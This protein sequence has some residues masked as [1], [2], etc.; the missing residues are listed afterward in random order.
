[1]CIL[2]DGRLLIRKEDDAGQSKQLAVVRPGKCIG[3][4]SLLDD[5]PCSATVQAESDAMLL[6]MTRE[7]FHALID[8]HP[9]L[10]NLFILKIARLL[11]LRLRQT[12]G[13]LVD[14]L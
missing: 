7:R 12:S 4:M 5:S 10:A 3:E 1:M 2:L 11:S 14:R 6:L 8:E 13:A 9:V